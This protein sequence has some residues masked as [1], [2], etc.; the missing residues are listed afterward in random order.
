MD[1]IKIKVKPQ[2]YKRMSRKSVWK[3]KDYHDYMNTIRETCQKARFEPGDALSLD[4]YIPMPKSW[5][6]KKKAEMEFEP[7]QNRPDLDNLVKA[8]LDALF[9]QKKGGDSCVY[10]LDAAKTWRYEGMVII[11]NL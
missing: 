1:Q 4:F 5:S 3:Y 8:V 9:Y 7:H 11:R 10:M 2:G 6:K